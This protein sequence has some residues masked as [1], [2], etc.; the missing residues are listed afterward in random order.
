VPTALDITGWTFGRLT[1]QYMTLKRGGRAYWSCAC[2]CGNRVDVC[3]GS[4]RCGKTRSCGCLRAELVAA[5]NFK[6]GDS[7]RGGESPEFGAYVE[8]RQRCTNPHN[9]RWARYGGRGIQFRFAD[10]TQWLAELGRKP[11]PG[12]S[13]DRIDNNGN[14]APGNVRWATPKEQRANQGR[15]KC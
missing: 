5:K 1:A 11:S 10:F 14:Y 7:P 3:L 2:D 4:L 9:K 15:C 8:A 12:H 6:H 13:V